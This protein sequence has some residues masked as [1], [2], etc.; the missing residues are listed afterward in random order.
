MAK[1][2]QPLLAIVIV[3][4]FNNWLIA[5][6]LNPHLSLMVSLISEISARS[7]PFHWIFQLGDC[8]AGVLLL[9]HIPQLRAATRRLR[10][11]QSLA[12][13]VLIAVIGADSIV[14]ALLPISCAPSADP[15]C[16]LASTH[17]LITYAHMFESTA[18]GV[19]IM[20]AP[21]LWWLASRHKHSNL[22]KLSLGF[23][24]LQLVVGAVVLVAQAMHWGIIGAAQRAYE[25]GIGLWLASLIVWSKAMPRANK[26]AAAESSFDLDLTQA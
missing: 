3:L 9:S 4:L 19:L 20:L 7:Q 10:L 5:P 17:S 11:Q 15:H 23:V 2:T 14:D 25:G 12:L 22:A 24:F 18:A 8:A 6:L 13:I 1:Y 21:I 26:Q 16:Q